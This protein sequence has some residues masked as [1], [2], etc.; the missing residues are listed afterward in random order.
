MLPTHHSRKTVKGDLNREKY[1]WEIIS[2]GIQRREDERAMSKEPESMPP[3]KG[4]SR[5]TC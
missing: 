4:K 3:S 2:N 1:E 5:N